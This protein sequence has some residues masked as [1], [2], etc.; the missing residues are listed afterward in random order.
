MCSQSHYL[1]ASL[2]LGGVITIE[3][4]LTYKSQGGIR[5]LEQRI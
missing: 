3:G 2:N 5:F 1:E 4:S